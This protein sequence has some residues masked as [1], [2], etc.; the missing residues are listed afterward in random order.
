MAIYPREDPRTTLPQLEKQIK[1]LEQIIAEL[2]K[3]IEDLENA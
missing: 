3:R 2:T 1:A